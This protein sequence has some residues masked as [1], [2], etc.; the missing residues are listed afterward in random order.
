MIQTPGEPDRFQLPVRYEDKEG[1]EIR[2]LPVFVADVDEMFIWLEVEAPADVYTVGVPWV[3][4]VGMLTE[5]IE[6]LKAKKISE[7]MAEIQSGVDNVKE[8]P[9]DTEA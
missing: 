8:R 5:P 4:V 9:S 1:K 2:H 7:A 6:E 3:E